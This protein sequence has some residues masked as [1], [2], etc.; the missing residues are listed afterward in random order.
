MDK[1]GW[2]ENMQ[3][4]HQRGEVWILKGNHISEMVEENE[5][6][7]E[8]NVKRKL[9]CWRKEPRTQDDIVITQ[10]LVFGEGNKTKHNI[11]CFCFNFLLKNRFI[12]KYQKRHWTCLASGFFCLLIA[13]WIVVNSFFLRLFSHL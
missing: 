3:R 11:R 2:R 9:W 13:V 6:G 1:C 7:K 4:G 12:V 10:I 8:A 5:T